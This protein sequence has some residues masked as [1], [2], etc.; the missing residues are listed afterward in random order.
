MTRK[1]ELELLNKVLLQGYYFCLRKDKI[2][3][4][5]VNTICVLGNEIIIGEEAYGDLFNGVTANEYLKRNANSTRTTVWFLTEEEAQKSCL[6][7]NAD[8]MFEKMGFN[9]R[10]EDKWGVS[11][12]KEYDGN[13]YDEHDSIHYIEIH[14]HQEE[15]VL[16]SS[17]RVYFVD[18]TESYNKPAN[19]SFAELEAINKKIEERSD[20]L[21]N[22]SL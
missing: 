12:C 7:N 10:I 5:P 9:K 18:G 22:H 8:E 1:Q 14:K 21:I 17:F 19:L 3:K 16:I 6:Q 15:K 2:C 20:L 13:E 11:Y 4:I